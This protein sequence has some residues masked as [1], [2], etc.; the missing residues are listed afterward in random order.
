MRSG[1]GVNKK[2]RLGRTTET[3]KLKIALP[4]FKKKVMGTSWR[5]LLNPYK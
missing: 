2:S 1:L 3:A 4:Y 5:E